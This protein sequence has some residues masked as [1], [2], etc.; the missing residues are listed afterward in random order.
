MSPTTSPEALCHLGDIATR[1][2][3]F[4]VV[5]WGLAIILGLGRAYVRSSVNVSTRA[6]RRGLRV[7]RRGVVALAVRTVRWVAERLR[8]W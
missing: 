5:G 1:M 2:A 6:L 3:L 4:W 8:R 7:V